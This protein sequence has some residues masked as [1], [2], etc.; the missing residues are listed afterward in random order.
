MSGSTARSRLRS[1]ATYCF[2]FV[3]VLRSKSVLSYGIT[4]PAHREDLEER[5]HRIGHTTRALVF[6]PC[7]HEGQLSAQSLGLDGDRGTP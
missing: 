4:P 7:C 5:P 1:W 2:R 6:K 3:R